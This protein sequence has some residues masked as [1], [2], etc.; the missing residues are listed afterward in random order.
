M[1]EKF[2]LGLDCET[3][4]EAI[5]LGSDAIDFLL[6][7]YGRDFVERRVG[8][9]LNQDLLTGLIDPRYMHF[10][11]NGNDI[12]A[13][14]K[15][16]HGADTGQRIIRRITDRKYGNLPIKYFTV[17]ANLGPTIL[18]QYSEFAHQ[19]RINVI[20]FTAHTKIPQDEVEETYN[21]ELKDVI[22]TLSNNALKGDC[23]SIVLEGRMLEYLGI[24]EIPLKKLV[25][26]IRI[27][28]SDRGTQ[29]RVTKL[30]ELARLKGSID[31]VVVSRRY[32]GDQRVLS[33]YFSALL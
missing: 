17:A 30:D 5:K 27:D 20:A 4:D 11:D 28:A 8:L 6:S 21:R 16:S 25:P 12:F 32:L 7:E 14:L 9:K 19:D 33:E 31:Y 13:D 29:N 1:I 26:G 18:R 24:K 23:D 2:F 10:V 15:I 3:D 22:C